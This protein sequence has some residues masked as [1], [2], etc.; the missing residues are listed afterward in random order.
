MADQGMLCALVY[1][2]NQ[3]NPRV[4]VEQAK[5]TLY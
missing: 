4:P 2:I 3:A 5:P 1:S